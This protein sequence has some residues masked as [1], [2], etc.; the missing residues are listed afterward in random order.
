LK[1]QIIQN[2]YPVITSGLSDARFAF[3]ATT[4][5]ITGDIIA[6]SAEIPRAMAARE[7]RA[8]TCGQS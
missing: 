2:T 3:A 6:D 4:L 8:V 5:A 7:V 1:Y